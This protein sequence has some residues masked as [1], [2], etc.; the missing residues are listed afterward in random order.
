MWY[1]LQKKFFLNVGKTLSYLR[2]FVLEYE[3]TIVIFEISTLEFLKN[4][5]LS[6]TVNFG[7]GSAF[8][9]GPGSDFLK[10]QV[11]VRVR[12]IKRACEILVL[13]NSTH[14][15][16]SLVESIRIIKKMKKILPAGKRWHSLCY[17]ISMEEN[18]QEHLRL[19]SRKKNIW[20]ESLKASRY[21]D[22]DID[23]W[24]TR[25]HTRWKHV[26]HTWTS[27][28]APVQQHR[29]KSHL[30]LINLIKF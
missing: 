17:Y 4:E 9:R 26:A 24:E 30:V 8:S 18:I 10:V 1:F 20:N 7:I 21:M 6:H 5:P 19:S 13:N 25:I 27:K 2:I 14:I 3:K 15:F 22:R 12:F 29:W 28:G 16:W 23:I 11:R